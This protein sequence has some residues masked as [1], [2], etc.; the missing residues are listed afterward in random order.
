[1][2][3]GASAPAERRVSFGE[4]PGAGDGAGQLR[5]TWIPQKPEYPDADLHGRFAGGRAKLGGRP[6]TSG[7]VGVVVLVKPRSMT[8]WSYSAVSG[9]R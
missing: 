7:G 8:S 6:R 4:A 2:P 3:A 5:L 9:A 1:M